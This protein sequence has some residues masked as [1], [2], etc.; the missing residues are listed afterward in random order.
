MSFEYTDPSDS[1]KDHVRFL[2]GDTI[3]E[4]FSLS[5]EEINFLVTEEGNIYWAASAAAEGMA[6]K[7]AKFV[8]NS[9]EGASAQDSQM[10]MQYREVARQLRLD[11]QRKGGTKVSQTGGLDKAGN[12]RD[13]IFTLGMHDNQ[14]QLDD[15]LTSPLA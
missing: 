12:K 14:E 5:D 10:F 2:V 13:P 9:M 11:A 1:D 8:S 7:V 6:A 4:T 15:P 3:E